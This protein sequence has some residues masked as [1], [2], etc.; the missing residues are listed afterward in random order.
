MESVRQP[1]FHSF[2]VIL[3]NV[4][5]TSGFGGNSVRITWKERDF[6]CR[7]FAI[8]FLVTEKYSFAFETV[9]ISVSV[10]KLYL[11]PVLAAILEQ[12][13]DHVTNFVRFPIALYMQVMCFST[14]FVLC[15]TLS[16]CMQ[17]RRSAKMN[18]L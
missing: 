8:V 3:T 1:K 14:T 11:L 16:V 12:R 7:T 5:S 15:S 18:Y 2:H 4:T 13:S 17:L 6:G 10:Q 9:S